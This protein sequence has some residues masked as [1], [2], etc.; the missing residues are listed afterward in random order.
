MMLSAAAGS[1]YF[2]IYSFKA[3]N[4]TSLLLFA[5]VER[6]YLLK[7]SSSIFERSWWATSLGYSW[8]EMMMPQ[9]PSDRAYEWNV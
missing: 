2:V 8:S 4:G 3:G 1:W 9:T 7:N 5:H 6:G